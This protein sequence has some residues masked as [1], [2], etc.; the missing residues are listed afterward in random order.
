VRDRNEKDV[1]EYK[2]SKRHFVATF[3]YLM[4]VIP[5]GARRTVMYRALCKVHW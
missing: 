1:E 5:I 2:K 3:T 4:L